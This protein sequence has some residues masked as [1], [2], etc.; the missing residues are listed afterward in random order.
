MLFGRIVGSLAN[1]KDLKRAL[2]VYWITCILSCIT[3]KLPQ[4]RSTITGCILGGIIVSLLSAFDSWLAAN[5]MYI[6]PSLDNI[7]ELEEVVDPDFLIGNNIMSHRVDQININPGDHIYSWRTAFAYSHHGIYIG[8]N[9]VIHYTPR[10][11]DSACLKH[12]NC[13]FQKPG[14]GVVL[15]CLDCFAGSRSLYLFQYELRPYVHILK[16]RGGTCTTKWIWTLSP[17]WKQL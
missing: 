17:H 9:H 14:S 5:H 13:G 11:N 4:N 8:G 16:F 12:P 7:L 2:I 3:T 6:A 15:S 1:K 10:V